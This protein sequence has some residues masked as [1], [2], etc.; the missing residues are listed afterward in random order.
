MIIA[1]TAVVFRPWDDAGRVPAAVDGWAEGSTAETAA[2]AKLTRLLLKLDDG[3]LDGPLEVGAVTLDA[4]GQDGLLCEKPQRRF[5]GHFGFLL[6][7]AGPILPDPRKH[8]RPL[9]GDRSLR[10]LREPE[11]RVPRIVAP[12]SDELFYS[13]SRQG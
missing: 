4:V 10:C 13:T 8:E 2:T 12:R 9:E 11:I 1:T 7:I 6:D 5:H 3:R